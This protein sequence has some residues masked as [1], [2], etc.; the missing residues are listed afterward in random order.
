MTSE[1][2][3]HISDI[4]AFRERR[5]SAMDHTS[6]T[7][8]LLQ[9]PECRDRLPLPT[10]DEF[11][12]CLMGSD[13]ETLEASGIGAGRTPATD[14]LA[15]KLFGRLA[16]RNAIFASFLLIAILGFSLFL[17]MPRGYSENENLV[18][19]VGDNDLQDALHQ[20]K[21]D[22]P[23]HGEVSNTRA[24]A[25][26]PGS[27]RS[28]SETADTKASKAIAGRKKETILKT[29]NRAIPN[30]RSLRQAKT[31]G[32]LP[33]GGQR[34][35]ALGAKQTDAG[36]LLTWEKVPGAASYSV[37][38]SDLDERLIDHFET[39]DATSYLVK[40]ALD[41]ATAY[42]FRLIVNLE[43]GERVVSES[44]NLKISDLTKGSQSLGNIVRKKTS[45]SVRCVEVKQ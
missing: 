26:S 45:A 23:V 29:N 33:C 18:G 42:R 17:L 38:L 11:W 27:R 4:L 19:A 21:P 16:I 7:R 39:A 44:Q 10:A 41:S 1:E 14:Y 36:L 37:Y 6:A 15:G 31:R 28:R 32:N 30:M 2:H 40:A 22:G 24:S 20:V 9:C 13:E 5:L 25:S 8:H 34:V 12:R 35:V 3:L 43:N